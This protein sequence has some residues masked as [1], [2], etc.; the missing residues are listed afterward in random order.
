MRFVGNW[1]N[2]FSRR[3]Q[4]RRKG[5]WGNHSPRALYGLLFVLP[6][7]LLD[8]YYIF[9]ILTCLYFLFFSF[10][11]CGHTHIEILTPSNEDSPNG[12]NIQLQD[13]NFKLPK[14]Y[15]PWFLSGPVLYQ[16]WQ[17]VLLGQFQ[18]PSISRHSNPRVQRSRKLGTYWSAMQLL[19]H[20]KFA[21]NSAQVM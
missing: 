8:L 21:T 9:A 15:Y 18:L 3:L 11:S 1:V 14:S 4:K 16:S 6:F 7:N 12:S 10:F 2:V 19:S 20:P 17:I 13:V 5:E